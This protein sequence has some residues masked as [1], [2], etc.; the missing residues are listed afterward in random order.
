[1]NQAT[2][3]ADLRAALSRGE[4]VALVTVIG[5]RGSAPRGPGARMLVFEDGRSQGSVSGGCLEAEAYA[6]AQQALE[7]LQPQ[8]FEYDLTKDVQEG[9]GMVCGG[10]VEVLVEAFA[11]EGRRGDA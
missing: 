7:S 6:R 10:K 1:M 5:V 11:P 8:R 9:E 2:L 3:L 4:R